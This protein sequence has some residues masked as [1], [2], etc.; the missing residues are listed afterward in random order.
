MNLAAEMGKLP[1]PPSNSKPPLWDAWRHDL[2]TRTQQ[3]DPRNFMKWPCVYHTMLQDHWSY[4]VYETERNYVGND[5]GQI[6]FLLDE[7]A[8]W[9]TPD[10]HDAAVKIMDRNMSSHRNL[11]HQFYHLLRWQEATGLRIADQRSIYEF[12]GGYGAMALVARRMGFAGTYYIYDLPEFALL[13][14]WYLEE[15][16]IDGVEWVGESAYGNVDLLIACYS[17]SETDFHERDLVLNMSVAT[18]Y[19]FLYSNKFEEYDNILY[20]Q[21]AIPA[22][23]YRNWAH[24]HIEHLP[25]E[26]WYTWG[27]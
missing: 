24:S 17:L 1:E 20:F 4:T 19:L 11:I 22:H 25:P 3:D 5:I 12:G 7:M 26:S 18:S 15:C 21:T 13:Q 6:A 27:W 2:W 14:Q 16:G 23:L 8:E 10:D 9:P